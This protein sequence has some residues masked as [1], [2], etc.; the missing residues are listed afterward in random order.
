MVAP[1]G[2]PRLGPIDPRADR[3]RRECRRGKLVVEA[4]TD[5]IVE[6][7]APLRRARLELG[8]QLS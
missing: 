5:V 4:P 7:L 2:V 6:R 8:P 1:P 3:R